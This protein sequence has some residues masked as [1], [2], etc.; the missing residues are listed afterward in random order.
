MRCR[1]CGT[2]N[3]DFASYCVKCGETLRSS[4]ADGAAG[5]TRD[6]FCAYCGR[7]MQRGTTFCEN[8]GH[9]SSLQTARRAFV[10]SPT[11]NVVPITQRGKLVPIGLAAAGLYLIWWGLYGIYYGVQYEWLGWGIIDYADTIFAC[12]AGTI[13][14]LTGIFSLSNSQER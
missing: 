14:L 12:L 5:M 10:Q 3:G 7:T 4:S 9:S 1:Y 13:A 6:G 2:E 8:C 11:Q